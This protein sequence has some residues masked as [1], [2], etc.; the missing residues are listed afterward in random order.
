MFKFHALCVAAAVS[1]LAFLPAAYSAPVYDADPQAVPADSVITQKRALYRQAKAAYKA[2]DFAKAQELRGRI[3]PY[4]LNVWLDYYALSSEPRIELF[5]QVLAFIKEGRQRELSTLLEDKYIDLMADAH[6]Y[7][8]VLKLLPKAPYEDED[9]L[10]GSKLGKQCRFYEA[11]WATG[12]GSD[13]AVAFARQLYMN[14]KS[15]PKQ[16]TGLLALY[17]AKGYLTDKT[18]YE[19]FG[20]AYVQRN[21][22][23][24]AR[25]L[26]GTLEG[27]PFGPSVKAALE[28]YESPEKWRELDV[29]SEDLREA[30][31][32]AFKRLGR[33]DSRLA[34]RSLDE[35]IAKVRPS[36][37]DMVDVYTIIAEQN[38]SFGRPLQ[39][40]LWVD[41]NLPAVGW[42]DFIK[43]QRLRR[44]IYFAQ[45]DIVYKLLDHI[46]PAMAAEINWRYWRGRSALEIGHKDEGMQIL[47]EVAKDRSFFGFLA[48]QSLGLDYAFNHQKINPAAQWP[49]GVAGDEAVKRFFE[50][51]AME[52]ANAIYEWREIAKRSTEEVSMLMAE[53]ALRTGNTR[54]AIESVISSGRWDALSY[55]FPIVYDDIYQKN[56]KE[57]G[58]ALSFLYGISRQESMLNPVIK[59]P[60]GAVGLM[61][62]MPG[63]AQLVS[64]QNKWSYGG[65]STLTNPEVNVR[66]GSAYIK[67]M[68]DKFS[69]NRILAAAAYNA[70]PGRIDRWESKDGRARDAAMFIENIPFAETRKYVQN[71]LLYDSI[72]YLLLT[73]KEQNLL[74]KGELAYHY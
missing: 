51:Y 16:C 35:F 26:A 65:V 9:G 38:L 43:E 22:E 63:T 21:Y 48:A 10:A 66:L 54:Y 27:T 47:S 45:W 13:R 18:R 5:A 64:R 46:K 36:D 59:S 57:T 69:N 60:A 29:S 14:L 72:Y 28:L 24:T 3:G 62:L 2:G 32:L 40:V 17:D 52:D 73:G 30:A 71:V 61:Q 11:Q 23:N 67:K 68:L 8:D 42:N 34:V 50:L 1:C 56:A 58:V 33:S 49:S 19:K 6:R 31:I 20:R 25:T 53:W 37:A 55:R 4:V 74:T 12:Q 15:K 41:R 39:D 7:E 44:A 70:G